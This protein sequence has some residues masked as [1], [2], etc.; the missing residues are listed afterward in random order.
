MFQYT[1]VTLTNNDIDGGSA[2]G[3]S[4]G[5]STTLDVNVTMRNNNVYGP[6]QASLL[7][8][9]QNVQSALVLNQCGWLGCDGASGNISSSLPADLVDA[10]MS[11]DP[12]TLPPGAS[13]DRD[14]VT[15]PQGGGWDIGPLEN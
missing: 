6:S 11:I 2:G 14:G 9:G 3:S 5:I 12:A 1:T 7:F 10:G 4:V 13:H 15:R 8:G